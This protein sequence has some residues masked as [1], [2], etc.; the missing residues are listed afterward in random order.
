MLSEMQFFV[1]LSARD[2]RENLLF[3]IAAVAATVTGM[4]ELDLMRA[5]TP[6]E[7]GQVLRWMQS[8]AILSSASSA[9]ISK[10]DAFGLRGRS[11]VACTYFIEWQ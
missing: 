11:R 8:V 7:Y 1:W 5:Q 2:A 4:L 3:T 10:R 6:A 9:C